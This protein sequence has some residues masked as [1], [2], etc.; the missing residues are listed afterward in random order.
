MS[1][2][3][4]ILNR[5]S[6]TSLLYTSKRMNHMQGGFDPSKISEVGTNLGLLVQVL[7]GP[8]TQRACK[9]SMILS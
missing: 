1:F 6:L 8:N 9:K 3:Y 2:I 4:I 5:V 7:P